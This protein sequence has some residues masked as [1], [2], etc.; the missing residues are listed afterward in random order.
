MF[1]V[2]CLGMSLTV[3]QGTP[4][5]PMPTPPATAGIVTV[6]D[7]L[8]RRIP[9]A[10]PMAAVP[11]APEVNPGRVP[12]VWTATQQKD[13]TSPAQG[14]PEKKDTPADKKQGEEKKTGEDRKSV[15]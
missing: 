8:P 5:P 1:D 2:F 13:P 14:E 12:G 3:G 15:V 4:A 6:G 10:L 7:D 9:A 11:P